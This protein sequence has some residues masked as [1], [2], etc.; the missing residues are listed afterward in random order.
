MPSARVRRAV[1]VALL[2][3]VLGPVGN[4][5]ALDPPAL[6][7]REGVSE[8]E[9]LGPW[10]PLDG[11]RIEGLGFI[12]GTRAQAKPASD[13]SIL[14]RLSALAVPDGHPDQG[15]AFDPASPC[16]SNA[17]PP[18]TEVALATGRFEGPG[19]YTIRLDA[20]VP[21][22]GATRTSCSGGSSST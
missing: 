4:A 11:A 20:D 16:M 22:N 13:S 9:P 5:Q 3:S 12:V 10:L 6:L 14:S 15:S 7:Y 21:S 8:S 17:S 1:G 19:T 2:V 18:G